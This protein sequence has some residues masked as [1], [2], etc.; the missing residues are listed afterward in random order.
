[1]DPTTSPDMATLTDT[2]AHLSSIPPPAMANTEV[3]T[4]VLQ[5]PVTSDMDPGPSPWLVTFSAALRAYYP[6]PALR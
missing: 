2:T 5:S 6:K 3:P 1:M 4:D